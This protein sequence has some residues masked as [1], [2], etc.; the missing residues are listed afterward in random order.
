MC[1]FVVVRRSL[2]AAALEAMV[3]LEQARLRGHLSGGD[4]VGSILN[5]FRVWY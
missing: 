5:T 2:I 1:P 4:L 3:S